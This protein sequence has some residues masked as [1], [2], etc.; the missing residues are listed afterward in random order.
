MKLG[1]IWIA[2]VLYAVTG[3]GGCSSSHDTGF[4]PV[5]DDGGADVEID[6]VA[7]LDFDHSVFSDGGSDRAFVDAPADHSPESSRVGEYC[8][9]FSDCRGRI[10]SNEGPGFCTWPCAPDIACPEGTLCD[11][12]A[13]SDFG[14]CYLRCDPDASECPSGLICQIKPG[15]SLPVPV[16]TP[17]CRNN[18]E[19]PSGAF[20][21]DLDSACHDPGAQVG[22]PCEHAID[23]PP[24]ASCWSQRARGFPA[25]MCVVTGCALP[26]AP[27]VCPVDTICI[28]GG[29]AGTCLPSCETHSDCR[30]GY[31]CV[32][33]GAEGSACV[34]RCHSDA[35]CAPGRC[36][37]ID[38]TCLG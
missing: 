4:S 5:S 33:S 30:R 38:A 22:T 34:P 25:G 24:D 32:S 18:D 12:P 20:C 31:E 21:S 10:C 28:R 17:G 11:L 6:S 7:D 26:D 14:I 36:N 9:T 3:A 27:S 15:S 19:C 35:D 13:G 2:P 23:C 37:V 29:F 1:G 8:E 16:C